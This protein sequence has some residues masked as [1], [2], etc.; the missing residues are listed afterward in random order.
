MCKGGIL[1][2]G[3]VGALLGKL[4]EGVDDLLTTAVVDGDIQDRFGTDPSSLTGL[5]H[6]VLE[7]GGKLVQ[8]SGEPQLDAA[9]RQFVDLAADRLR[10]QVHQGIDLIPPPPPLLRPDAL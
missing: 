5:P 7:R 8:P 10:E 2:L 9:A 3:Q 6:L 1:E 4:W